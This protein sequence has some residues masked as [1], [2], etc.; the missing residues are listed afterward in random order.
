VVDRIDGA[1]ARLGGDGALVTKGFAEANHLAVG[2]KLAVTTPAGQHGALVVRG[3][4]DSPDSAPLLGDVT[5]SREAFDAF[6]SPRNSLTL[7]NNDGGHSLL[8]L[9]FSIVVSLMGMVN[10]RVLSVVERTREIGMLR[11]LA[12]IACVGAAVLPARRA[13]RLNVLD[14]VSCE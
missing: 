6:R 2:T 11:A 9:G 10:T 8:L 4:Y 12:V 13:S 14:A 1:L 3:I 5:I 7:I